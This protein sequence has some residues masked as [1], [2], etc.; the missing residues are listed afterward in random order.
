MFKITNKQCLICWNY[1]TYC[2]PV[3]KMQTFYQFNFTCNCDGLYHKQCLI[4]WNSTKNSCPTCHKSYYLNILYN[5][6]KFKNKM[7]VFHVLFSNLLNV[8]GYISNICIIINT[9]I[10]IVDAIHQKIKI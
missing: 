1:S 2:K 6:N 4:D 8:L 9:T 10:T 3:E 5:N 7:N